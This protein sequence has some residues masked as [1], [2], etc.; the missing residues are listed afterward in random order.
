MVGMIA[1][2]WLICVHQAKYLKPGSHRKIVKD[3]RPR[4]GKDKKILS[5]S[6]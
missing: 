2:Y 1:F 4:T 3:Y 6:G 5:Q